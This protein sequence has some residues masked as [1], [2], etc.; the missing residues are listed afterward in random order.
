MYEGG[1]S[2]EAKVGCSLS[3]DSSSCDWVM[4]VVL[5]YAGNCH[6]DSWRGVCVFAC[7]AVNISVY[8]FVWK[9]R[10][11]ITTRFGANVKFFAVFALFQNVQTRHKIHTF[12]TTPADTQGENILSPAYTHTSMTDL[13][14]TKIAQAVADACR[15]DKHSRH[16]G[17]THAGNIVKTKWLCTCLHYNCR[18]CS[19]PPAGSLCGAA[20][21]RGG[22][23]FQVKEVVTCPSSR[24]INQPAQ[25]H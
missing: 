10:Q 23:A 12:N 9:W 11:G 17:N 6:A 15:H 2:R 1:E 25:P 13:H 3:S 5:R 18:W 24:P 21:G 4:Q 22:V 20:Y 14:S 16:S 8:I 19:K 7:I